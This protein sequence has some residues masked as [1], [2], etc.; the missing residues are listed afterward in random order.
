METTE[1]KTVNCNSISPLLSSYPIRQTF[2]S[3]SVVYVGLLL[4]PI[5][6]SLFPWQVGGEKMLRQGEKMLGEVFIVNRLGIFM[7]LGNYVATGTFLIA[8]LETGSH[9]WRV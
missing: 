1:S 3:P 8:P 4:L 5:V 6:R 7:G 2:S 9:C